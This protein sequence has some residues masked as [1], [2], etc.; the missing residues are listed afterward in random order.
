MRDTNRP[1]GVIKLSSQQIERASGPHANRTLTFTCV[2]ICHETITILS[3]V[4]R[5]FHA[6]MITLWAPFAS[7]EVPANIRYSSK[8]TNAIAASVERT[9]TTATPLFLS[10]QRSHVNSRLVM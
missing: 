8:V 5:R 3:D 10:G 6:V 4:S 2:T 7:L 1:K 9:T